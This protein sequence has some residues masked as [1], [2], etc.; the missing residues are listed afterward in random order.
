[1]SAR[2]LI[3]EASSARTADLAQAL[4]AAGF[5]VAGVVAEDADVYGAVQRL[6]PDA[7][8]IDT[9]SPTRDTLEGLAVI[10]KRFPRPILLLSEAANA[11][12]VQDAALLG[13]SAYAVDGFSPG[14]LKSLIEVGIA[15]FRSHAVLSE[16]LRRTREA[17]RERRQIEQAKLRLMLS[18]QLGEDEAYHHLRR[19]AMARGLR[20]AEL[21]R[22]LLEQAPK[23][24]A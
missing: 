19:Q 15:H 7:I 6:A 12:L 8:L 17:L 13:I 10:G 21:A 14:L 3:V 5:A 2:V 23:D 9:E 16:E 1:M 11:E 22:E 4:C 20:I 24:Q 18:L